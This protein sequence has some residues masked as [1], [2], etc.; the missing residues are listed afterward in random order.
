MTEEEINEAI[1]Y[2]L[3]HLEHDYSI[4]EKLEE[5]MKCLKETQQELKRKDNIINE[6]KDIINR[7][8]YMGYCAKTG[9]GT[10][11]TNFMAT[12]ENSEFGTRAKYILDKIEEL[13]ND[14]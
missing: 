9:K 7:M 11:A 8:I 12:G 6:V 14:N 2:N 13:E 3:R 1:E 4:E 5:T 10:T